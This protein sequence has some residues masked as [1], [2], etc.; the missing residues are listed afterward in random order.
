MASK[1]TVLALA[2]SGKRGRPPTITAPTACPTCGEMFIIN[3]EYRA[4]LLTH[5]N[6]FECEA[7]GKRFRL[8]EDLKAHNRRVH[9]G[10]KDAFACELCDK[11]FATKL[12]WKHHRKSD[13]PE[14]VPVEEEK[15][16]ACPH[17]PKTFARLQARDVHQVVHTGERKHLCSECGSSFGSAST[18]IDHRK[19][20]H[21]EIRDYK[22][23]ECHKAFFTRQELEA[24]S[25][26][27]SGLK[28]F[29]CNQCGKNFARV[30][31]LRRH[32][33]CVHR[34][35]KDGSKKETRQHHQ[36]QQIVPANEEPATTTTTTT[37][38]LA[39]TESVDLEG[40]TF[41]IDD[42][43]I[44]DGQRYATALAKDGT[45]IL[46]QKPAVTGEETASTAATSLIELSKST[47]ATTHEDKII[48]QIDNKV[49][50]HGD[51]DDGGGG[52]VEV[53]HQDG[54]VI[55]LVTTDED[56]QQK[57]SSVTNT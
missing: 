24:H 7:C 49:S 45:T 11:A 9:L 42:E 38:L 18:L 15:P 33:D 17:C 25:R 50:D 23:E 56:G 27:H 2:G 31:H 57:L 46:V 40:A 48:M 16:F 28:P 41:T 12:D 44:L 4:H 36:Q 13:H 55:F 53:N 51:D 47:S 14:S 19:R 32:I 22:C 35:R 8:E 52:G 3:R 39:A 26:V 1:A 21:L 37:L 5:T 29:V 43:Y 6:K 30:H 34:N 54:G 20:R 10:E